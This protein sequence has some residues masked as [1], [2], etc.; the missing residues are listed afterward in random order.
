MAI[1]MILFCGLRWNSN[2][3]GG[4]ERAEFRRRSPSTRFPFPSLF[5]SLFSFSSFQRRSPF[6]KPRHLQANVF[7]HSPFLRPRPSSQQRHVQA[8]VFKYSPFLTPR[9]PLQLRP[10]QAYVFKHSPFLIPHPTSQ[11]RHL[12]AYVFRRCTMILFRRTWAWDNYRIIDLRP[13]VL[14]L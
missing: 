7:K 10:L 2:P 5:F 14:C 12:Q 6:L 11:L 4:E 3:E 1:K 8:F 9:P 13:F